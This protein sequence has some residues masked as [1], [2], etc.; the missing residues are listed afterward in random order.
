MPFPCKG[1]NHQGGIQNE[2]QIVAYLNHHRECSIVQQLAKECGCNVISFTHAGGTQQKRDASYLLEDG[3]IKGL[4]I[5]NHKTGTFDL[6]NTTKGV[7]EDLKS[8]ILD[9][10]EKNFQK[11][12]PKTGGIR[13]DLDNV[14]SGWLDRLTSDQVLEL[15]SKTTEGEAGTDMII[16]NDVANKQ[17]VMFDESY[18]RPHHEP[19]D[20]FV[21]KST[22]RARTSR[23]IWIRSIDGQERNTN[24][25]IRLTLNNGLGALLGQSTSN[26][27]SVPCLKVQLDGEESLIANCPDKVTVS[28]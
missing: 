11:E 7:P 12:I 22:P 25:R 18:V 21:L 13:S 3:R 27:T 15:V 16:I 1:E 28:Y 8:E 23:Q 4:S 19:S 6:I 5:K 9:F 24:L 2:H 20:T 10:K 14:F 17:Y 26:K